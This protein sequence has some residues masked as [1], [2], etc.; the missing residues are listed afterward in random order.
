MSFVCRVSRRMGVRVFRPCVC[1]KV[2]MCERQYT[3]VN[4]SVWTGVY[5]CVSMNV[6]ANVSMYTCVF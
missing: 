6:C 3:C 5:T 4:V 1:V 2:F